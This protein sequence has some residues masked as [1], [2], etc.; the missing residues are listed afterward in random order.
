M[1]AA[2]VSAVLAFA[3]PFA[4]ACGV[5][6][7]DKIASTYDHAVLQRAT[8]RGHQVVYCEISGAMDLKRLAA[9]T[10]RQR[11]VDGA[12]IRIS[13]NPPALSFALDTKMQSPQA[14]AAAIQRAGPRGARV[15]VLR[16]ASR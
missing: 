1:K 15:S 6:A 16:V 10:A 4:M 3:A 5:C 9:A 13:R 14:A 12:S 2:I 8:A 11:G 7:E